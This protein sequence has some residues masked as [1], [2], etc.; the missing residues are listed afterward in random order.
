MVVAVAGRERM[1]R[2]D[3]VVA[4]LKAHEDELRGRGVRGLFLFGSVGRGEERAGSDVDLFFDHR[5]GL[6]LEVV[7]IQK[8]V[9][10]I[11]PGKV[12]VTTRRSLHPLLRERI[13]A[14]AV[15]VF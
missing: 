7:A 10:E 8:R 3:R 9:R 5:P 12:D 1:S 2:R 6:G 11:V 15:R 4:L 13:A 14:S